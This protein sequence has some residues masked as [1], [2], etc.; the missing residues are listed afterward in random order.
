MNAKALTVLGLFI[1]A[2][3]LTVTLSQREDAPSG[4]GEIG[5]PLLPGLQTALD[6]IDTVTVTSAE[7]T[8][9]LARTGGEWGVGERDGY[10][11]DFADLSGLTSAL[12]EAKYV[13][14]KTARAENLPRMGLED[15][16]AEGSTSILVSLS[17]GDAEHTI[18]LGERATGRTGQ[19]V[20]FPDQTQV[21]QID[22]YVSV[23]KSLAN[24]LDQTI[25]NVLSDRVMRV[26][27]EHPDGE[28]LDLE[29]KDGEFKVPDLAEGEE[30]K[31]GSVASE[32]SRALVNMR[33]TDV[34]SA[35]AVA[36]ES[37]V[38]SRYFCEDGL[39]V[40]VEAVE[41][42]GKHYVRLAGALNESVAEI[43]DAIK[44]EA[45]AIA[46]RAGRTFEVAQYT[47]RDVTKRRADLLKP[48]EEEDTA[49]GES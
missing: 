29:K 24:W 18:L 38:V 13:E 22:Q 32:L 17:G 43:D 4:D 20:R 8:V 41:A 11:A 16:T 37:P 23:E 49:E 35:D 15:M 47:Y 40:T 31:Y 34:L 36:W 19:Y 45:Q 5:Q 48:P 6:S 3:A 26:V 12:A 27:V 2:A 33:M 10:P 30:L 44:A 14:R 25:I 28:R 39:L 1:L 21:W 46:A 9:S 7:G 42:D